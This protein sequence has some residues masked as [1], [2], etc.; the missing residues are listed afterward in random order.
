MEI[1]LQLIPMTH[2]KPRSGRSL[3]DGYF[4]KNAVKWYITVT[5]DTE[6][7]Q[8]SWMC[9]DQNDNTWK[10]LYTSIIMLLC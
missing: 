10:K 4:E 1:A 8:Q 7:N 6:N 3:A 5:V 2:T 9:F